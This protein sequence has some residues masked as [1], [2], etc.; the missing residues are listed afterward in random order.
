M[1]HDRQNEGPGMPTEWLP[2]EG[3]MGTVVQRHRH[4]IFRYLV[5]YQLIKSQITSLVGDRLL[6]TIR[7]SLVRIKRMVHVYDCCIVSRCYLSRWTCGRTSVV[8][9]HWIYFTRTHD[10][11]V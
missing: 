9:T 2:S 1:A 8:L 10:G 7:T 6:V 3:T 5:N 4:L 11:G